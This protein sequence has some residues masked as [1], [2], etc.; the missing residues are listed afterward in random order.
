MVGTIEALKY[1]GPFE[2]SGAFVL[3]LKEW[4]KTVTRNYYFWCIRAEG[5]TVLVDAGVGPALA[6]ERSLT[7]YVNPARMIGGIGLKAE[8]VE[9]LVVT[10][11]HWDHANG[12]S[13]FP[14]ARYYVQSK[15][16]RFWLENPVSG[17]PPFRH[18]AD[19]AAV[20]YLSSFEG[21][22]QLCL[23]EGDTEIL[24]GVRCLLAPGHTVGLQ[25]VAVDTEAGV[26]VLG[27]DCAHFF[28][29]Y[30]EDWPSA[31]IV[32]LVAWMDSYE[33]LRNAVGDP[34]L[35]FPGHDPLLSTG[36]PQVAPGITRLV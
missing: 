9:H 35:L 6:R 18:L 32:D 36:Y 12:V 14:N 16:Y 7:G 15:E 24:P 34:S 30:R 23:L 5:T 1:A 8:E 13:L 21:K 2:S 28:R 10:H 22:S 26:A 27:S 3:W 20:D 11:L 31:L 33:K 19:P 17:R 29:N 25:A 4:E